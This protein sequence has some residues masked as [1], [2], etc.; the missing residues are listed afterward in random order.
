MVLFFFP[1]LSMPS[2]PGRSIGEAGECG[3]DAGSGREECHPRER[4]FG[5]ARRVRVAR[6]A[7]Q[8]R[9]VGPERHAAPRAP[10][11][12]KPVKPMKP[13]KPM[14]AVGVVGA[15]ASTKMVAREA[16]LVGA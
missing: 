7:R 11:P 10:K 9:P 12:M 6:V 15:G 1:D 4:P 8:A 5:E 14:E 3:P 2:P 13:M 16:A